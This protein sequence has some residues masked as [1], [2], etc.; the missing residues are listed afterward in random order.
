[1]RYGRVAQTLRRGRQFEDALTR[2]RCY[3][4]QDSEWDCVCITIAVR[5]A[6]PWSEDIKLRTHNTSL[7][8]D[9]R[10]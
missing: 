9:S 4:K 3:V 8:I 1:V 5:V 6:I 2:F 10:L 7:F